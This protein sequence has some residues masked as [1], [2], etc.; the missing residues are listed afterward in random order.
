LIDSVDR[1]MSA[2]ATPGAPPVAAVRFSVDPPDSITMLFIETTIEQR[3][4]AQSPPDAG[5]ASAEGRWAS[6]R[7]S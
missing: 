7:I 4:C 3:G 2:T 6:R 1:A 5:A